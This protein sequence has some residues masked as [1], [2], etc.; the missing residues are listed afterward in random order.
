[1]DQPAS[2]PMVHMNSVCSLLSRHNVGASLE[3]G[4]A[5]VCIDGWW[6]ML[7]LGD[8]MGQEEGD[9]IKEPKAWLWHDPRA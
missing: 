6:A 4:L 1:M 8:P 3:Q 5:L 7:S 9:L 2:P